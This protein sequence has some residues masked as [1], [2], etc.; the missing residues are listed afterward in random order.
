MAG[1]LILIVEDDFD[2][3]D[4]LSGLLEE[5]G[6]AVAAVGHGGEA[7]SWLSQNPR[8]ACI[9][10]D[11]I[12]KPVSGGE[13][14]ASLRGDGA[15]SAIPLVVLSALDPERQRAEVPGARAYLRKPSAMDELIQTLR[16]L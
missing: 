3:R 10:L 15:L 1:G 16:K 2:L 12:L 8:P 7:L 14:A 11:L 6:F 5:E 4:S 13:L 9:L